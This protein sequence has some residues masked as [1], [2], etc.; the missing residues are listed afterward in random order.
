VI[1]EL[2]QIDRPLR[3]LGGVDADVTVRADRKIPLTPPLDLV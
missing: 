2:L 3:V 1:D